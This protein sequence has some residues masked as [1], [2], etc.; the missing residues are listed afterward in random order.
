MSRL[1]S[2]IVVGV[3]L[4]EYGDLDCVREC[5]CRWSSTCTVSHVGSLKPRTKP[6]QQT[7]EMEMSNVGFFPM[8]C[9]VA[10]RDCSRVTLSGAI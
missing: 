1:S 8:N 4:S 7:S 9:S 10:S 2:V 5:R 6:A 3:G